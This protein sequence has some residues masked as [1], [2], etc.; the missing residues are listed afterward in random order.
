MNNPIY[1]LLLFVL[2]LFASLIGALHYITL[3]DPYFAYQ[4]VLFVYKLRC[5]DVH[6]NGNNLDLMGPVGFPREWE[7]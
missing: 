7:W 1:L 3:Q 5:R 4:I 6:G 2:V